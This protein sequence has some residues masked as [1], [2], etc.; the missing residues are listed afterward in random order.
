M[1]IDMLYTPYGYDDINMIEG[2]YSPST[3]KGYNNASF[4]YWERAL[5]Q[6]ACSCLDFITPWQG[7]IKDFFL[8]CLFR[9]GYVCISSNDTYGYYF[10]PCTLSGRNFYYQPTKV[11]ISNPALSA[12]LTIGQDCEL[13][14]L[15]P[16]YMGIWD[17][18]G[19]YA[20][21]LS[22][23]DN[24]IN[25]G[26]VNNKI[27]LIVGATSKNGAAVL[28]SALDEI[29]KGN[30]AVVYDTKL[31]M[32]DIEDN[33]PWEIFEHNVDSNV[34]TLGNQLT[35]RQ[36]LLHQFDNEVGIPTL[37]YEDKRERMIVDE[38]NAM[39]IDA[40]SRIIIWLDTLHASIDEI[41][42]LYPDM[43]LD[44]IYRDKTGG[45]DNVG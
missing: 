6:R 31:I 27:A 18:I 41:K 16:D 30:P 3:I 13:L 11:I 42:K 20:S 7:K 26:L 23:L 32:D 29:N 2:H 45:V 34:D 33:S 40:V 8:W 17:I 28:K 15:T 9:F 21:Q 1:A 10:Q 37:P 4:A 25:I 22:E 44:V 43:T 36:T 19:F 39:T 24:A 5:F 35:Q 14:K 38:A 12:T